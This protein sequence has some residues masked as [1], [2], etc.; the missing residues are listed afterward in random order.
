MQNF[1]K[2]II[3]GHKLHSHTHSYVH[4]AFVKA[5]KY[6][7]YNTLWLDNSDDISSI[8]FDNCLF[9]TEGQVDQNMP[10]N[11]TSKYIGHNIQKRDEESFYIP[12]LNILV[13]TKEALQYGKEKIND[14]TFYNK[15][16]N[17]IIQP[18]ATDLLPHEIDIDKALL[19]RNNTSYFF[20]TVVNSGWNNN[21]E[22]ILEFKNNC[23]KNEIAFD[24]QGLYTKG[25][26]IDNEVA[27]ELMR[28]SMLSP[29]IQ[30]KA[31]IELGYIPCR[32]FKNI[33]YGL[34]GITN[35]DTIYNVLGNNI[36]YDSN[37]TQMFNKAIELNKTD[38]DK[39]ILKDQMDYVK[40]NH[41]YINRIDML[42][43]CL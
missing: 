26:F 27:I 4:S 40:N 34:Y 6:L 38:V 37:I 21:Y 11:K 23:E 28:N 43:E 42:L 19:P 5:F 3:W 30:S 29:V 18:W 35:S 14:Y 33:S 17:L 36:I 16:S 39:K 9:I 20:G 7:G 8:N 1:N 10:R 15:E 32:I 22:E 2:V 13:Y 12:N 25:G 41:T 31:Q 24:Y